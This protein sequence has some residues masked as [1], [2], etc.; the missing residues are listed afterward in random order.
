MT[1]AI[2]NIIVEKYLN[3]LISNFNKEETKAN[4]L[5]GSFTLNK[6]SLNENILKDLN[7]S[8]LEL[9]KSFIDTLE[10]KT[11]FP[12]F[13]LNP[14]KISINKL[15]LH[16]ILNDES[17]KILENEKKQSQK[18][19][20][21]KLNI[22]EQFLGQMY[23]MNKDKKEE[24]KTPFSELLFNNIQLNIENIVIFCEYPFKTNDKTIYYRLG[25]SLKK[26]EFS[27]PRNFN[28]DSDSNVNIE[29]IETNSNDMKFCSK[30]IN[31][32]S[33]YLYL[34]KFK[35]EILEKEDDKKEENKDSEKMEKFSF[36]SSLLTKNQKKVK[37]KK[38]EKAVGLLFKQGISR[39]KNKRLKNEGAILFNNKLVPFN[40]FCEDECL[41]FENKDLENKRHNYIFEDINLFF[42]FIYDINYIKNKKNFLKILFNLEQIKANLTLEQ[43][44]I[45]LEMIQ[46]SYVSNL[47]QL[48][49]INES[50][51]KI[52][53]TSDKETYINEYSNYFIQKYI[54]Q[55]DKCEYPKSIIPLD[56]NAS[57]K[58]IMKVRILALTK[59]PQLEKINFLFKDL[60]ERFFQ[61]FLEE[62]Q[63][64]LDGLKL[65]RTKSLKSFNSDEIN[66]IKLEKEIKE[67]LE[68]IP[69]NIEIYY[70]EI[71]LTLLN[72]IV[73]EGTIDEKNT[74]NNIINTNLNNEKEIK[75]EYFNI[76]LN[77]LFIKVIQKKIEQKLEIQLSDVIILYV[78]QS[79]RVKKILY[80]TNEFCSDGDNIFS[81]EYEFNPISNLT[82]HKLKIEST[83]QLFMILNFD[84][85][86]KILLKMESELKPSLLKIKPLFNSLSKRNRKYYINLSKI[87][88]LDP[89]FYEFKNYYFDINII[90]PLFVLPVRIS[91][92]GRIDSCIF[93]YPG[94]FEINTL[95]PTE[96]SMEK[97]DVLYKNYI[98]K[99]KEMNIFY[100]ERYNFEIGKENIFETILDKF[101]ID[102]HLDSLAKQNINE[103]QNKVNI[104]LDV[105]TLNISDKH[106]KTM[107]LYSQSALDG[108]DNIYSVFGINDNSISFLNLYD[109]LSPIET[110][111]E[112]Q[113]FVD[114]KRSKVIDENEMIGM[115]YNIIFSLKEININLLKVMSEYEQS[116]V[117]G[118]DIDSYLTKDFLSLVITG[119]NFH[120]YEDHQNN[121]KVLINI[122][123]INLFDYDHIK[124]NKGETFYLSKDYRCVFKSISYSTLSNDKSI[125]EEEEEEDKNLEIEENEKEENK[126]KLNKKEEENLNGCLYLIYNFDLSKNKKK[127]KIKIGNIEAIPNISTIYRVYYFFEKLQ[128]FRIANYKS[129]GNSLHRDLESFQLIQQQRNAGKLEKG[130]NPKYFRKVKHNVKKKTDKNNAIEDQSKETISKNQ[131]ESVTVK[132]D[133]NDIY[134][135]IFD[136]KS[137]ILLEI[138]NISLKIP[139]Q[140]KEPNCTSFN[141]N[142]TISLRMKTDSQIELEFNKSTDKITYFNYLNRNIYV[143]FL[144]SNVTL[145]INEFLNDEII[146][147]DV[148]KNFRISARSDD[149]LVVSSKN[150]IIQS[151]III[152]PVKI[153]FLCSHI[154]LFNIIYKDFVDLKSGRTGLRNMKTKNSRKETI[155]DSFERKQA[156][157]EYLKSKRQLREKIEKYK[158]DVLS[159]Q[160]YNITEF[161]IN[162]NLD[163]DFQK[164]QILLYDESEEG[165][166][167][168]LFTINFDDI[169]LNSIHNSNP[170]DG[171]NMGNCI[172]EMIGEKEIPFNQYN[173]NTMFIFELL[174]TK[175]SVFYFNSSLNGYEPLIEP[176][177]ILYRKT[178]VSK[179]TRLKYEII[180]DS[181]LNINITPKGL[182]VLNKALNILKNENNVNA[183]TLVST[184]K[185]REE[186]S[187]VALVFRNRCGERVDIIFSQNFDDN[188]NSFS[189]SDGEEQKYSQVQLD[190]VVGKNPELLNQKIGYE[191][192]NFTIQNY[193]EIYYFDFSKNK[194]SNIILTPK[195]D[196]LPNYCINVSVNSKNLIKY[197]TFSSI[198]MV[199]NKTNIEGLKLC[200]E[201]EERDLIKNKKIFLPLEWAA[202]YDNVNF[203]YQDETFPIFNN[204]LNAKTELF[205]F[206]SRKSINSQKSFSKDKNINTS[207]DVDKRVLKLIDKNQ[208]N[209]QGK[210][211]CIDSF[212]LEPIDEE[213]EQKNP[214]DKNVEDFV[215]NVFIT[216]PVKI[217]SQIPSFFPFYYI[218]FTS[219]QRFENEIKFG[220]DNA[221]YAFPPNDT[222]S[223][224][225]ILI[226]MP[227]NMTYESYLFN[228]FEGKETISV[229][230][231]DGEYI[232]K[233][234]VQNTMFEKDIP[235]EEQFNISLREI[236]E[237]QKYLHFN[238]I[239]KVAPERSLIKSKCFIFYI[240]YIV[241]NKTML[242][243]FL[244]PSE[245]TL[246]IS[247]NL[248]KNKVS[249]LS[250]D[251]DSMTLKC[252]NRISKPF[253]INSIG[254][255]GLVDFEPQKKEFEIVSEDQNIDKPEIA[256]TIGSSNLFP[257]SSIITFEPRYMFINK[258]GFPIKVKPYFDE[259]GTY[260]F[261]IDDE[262]EHPLIFARKTNKYMIGING[263]WSEDINIE[264]ISEIDVKIEI[265]KDDEY[266]DRSC[267]SYDN[268]K[269]YMIIRV[270]ITTIDSALIYIT[271]SKPKY[272]LFEI[273]NNTN[274]SVD[275]SLSRTELVTIL[276]FK[277]VPFVR[278]EENSEVKCH[279]FK[280]D[281]LFSF[282]RFDKKEVQF[283]D[284]NEEKIIKT[285]VSTSNNG[286]TRL[287]KIEIDIPSKDI[288]V[289]RKI[290]LNKKVPKITK[291]KVSLKGIGISIINSKPQEIAYLSIYGIDLK[292]SNA[293]DK[294]DAISENNETIQFFIKNAQIDYCLNDWD[295]KVI[296][297][298]KNQILPYNEEKLFKE[299]KDYYPFLQVLICRQKT[300]NLKTDEKVEKFPQI[301]FILQEFVINLS[302]NSLEKI[303]QTLKEY[304]SILTI[305]HIE[306]RNLME[307]Q[308]NL[309]TTE[310]NI[311]ED[312]FLM[313]GVNLE[314]IDSG[315]LLFNYIFFSAIKFEININ[316]NISDSEKFNIPIFLRKL[317][318][319]NDEN[320]DEIKFENG[321]IK[322]REMIYENAFIGLSK[323][324][325]LLIKHYQTQT[326]NQFYQ[327]LGFKNLI[328]NP[329][330]LLD[331]VGTGFIEL[332]NETRKGFML[333][334]GY[335]GKR[336]NLGI[337]SLI[338]DL[339]NE[340]KE[341][342]TTATGTLLNMQNDSN[343]GEIKKQIERNRNKYITK[344]N[345]L[346]LKSESPCLN[347]IFL[348]P[349]KDVVIDG[350]QSFYKKL[351]NSNNNNNNNNKNIQSSAIIF[352]MKNDSIKYFIG[353]V[354]EEVRFRHPRVITENETIKVYKENLAEVQN[355]LE[356]ILRIYDTNKILF[357]ADIKKEDNNNY[358][359]VIMTD[360]IFIIIDEKFKSVFELKVDDVEKVNVMKEKDYFNLYFE[361]KG[362]GKKSFKFYEQKVVSK[363]YDLFRQQIREKVDTERMNTEKSLRTSV[364]M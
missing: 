265:S 112:S 165:K 183:M 188:T 230:K 100:S 126:I 125:H 91:E 77:N 217:E 20:Q 107:F 209:S 294:K 361:S 71:R 65:Q 252:K 40:E 155:L 120:S 60:G 19:K 110:P 219:E 145:E 185:K 17:N 270:S 21:E 314:K 130:I 154:K 109:L 248:P 18:L 25:F 280:T 56:E 34:D 187:N 303:I 356:D 134:K 105:L 33:G 9:K 123:N 357:F 333:G 227:P 147:Y 27:N 236:D 50:F 52:L 261:S 338:N 335:F 316:F 306:Q 61:E 263:N 115:K 51:M 169:K 24:I 295:K 92:S 84:Y 150:S 148:I 63:K 103:D 271:F 48:N 223:L 59:I 172:I 257:N 42:S 256:M 242:N 163:V 170:S 215:F 74:N 171:K 311:P 274:T 245:T 36:I 222:Q 290:F 235:P 157:T 216:S 346:E 201:E 175:F 224:M 167:I 353:K 23:Q 66:D 348:N 15:Y 299:D 55:N 144:L 57:Y 164:L 182:Y 286:F 156:V 177:H 72:I 345:P 330:K 196:N 287:F 340:G 249:L 28:N 281:I 87:M 358:N 113:K 62:N 350:V 214:L 140:P 104:N 76:T 240:D 323:L 297:V 226:R 53:S 237:T 254:L 301:D 128:E 30:K 29:E 184:I 149:N 97:K 106:L 146:K 276:P 293:I 359:T 202:N 292:Y 193:N 288:S 67:N 139:V 180:S 336:L 73:Y 129:E 118:A 93:V 204:I 160:M 315:M 324:Y 39:L 168:T 22:I 173:K 285:S 108:I 225:K 12:N 339:Y 32:I 119:I 179:E 251:R 159:Q 121:I 78:P 54:E 233:S 64:K 44:Q 232:R 90:S 192:I 203:K 351:K 321:Q 41:V 142:S 360:K 253:K 194:S 320:S 334:P 195:D 4:L 296:F 304:Y 49:D 200:Y 260:S 208:K 327:N 143:S 238:D 207:I 309:L 267:F 275:L 302:Q 264:N 205:A 26:F 88:E 190:L 127:L 122:D 178:K 289:V 234:V 337:H 117:K 221:I 70:F 279:L 247:Y 47:N 319:E 1:S 153:N 244:I 132:T 269:F 68:N 363:L 258:I 342:L 277:T 141:L 199:E 328:T 229:I 349:Y 268:T 329:I 298:P 94:K 212:A 161:N 10:V 135:K 176:Y 102:I 352:E 81:L 95:E 186:V 283:K 31:F 344:G 89:S 272:P 82:Q 332:V 8:C 111:N 307:R 162:F 243:L 116:Y 347:G 101:N 174:E 282:A 11:S 2:V 250:S 96:S 259:D 69:N 326:I 114:K 355:L 124:S 220:D 255:G 166:K 284:K 13:Y 317:E 210:Y 136:F 211:I 137:S 218:N 228:I 58:D 133:R 151:Y 318:K 273:C 3:K 262:T 46:S 138:S 6:I 85:W 191:E 14:I 291:I 231:D 152:E 312:N 246:N 79:G 325:A 354:P 343:I 341:Y 197:V 241:I 7:C 75:V 310:I 213:A 35:V 362:S 239:F 5:S 158:R 86:S 83:K 80:A 206:L 266:F 308:S 322:F 313:G 189:L 278:K 98:I 16:F 99:L 43:I 37:E 198:F 45:I 364:K 305:L 300:N 38:D 131:E 331:S 181:M